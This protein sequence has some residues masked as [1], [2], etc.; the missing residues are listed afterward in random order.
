MRFVRKALKLLLV[1]VV[2]F[3][4]WSVFRADT[5]V[6]AFRRE[7]VVNVSREVAWEHFS[8]PKTWNSWM[9]GGAPSEVTPTDVIGPD[10]VAR[11]GDALTFRMTQFEP[12]DHWMWSSQMGWLT[13]DYD[14]R[15]ERLSDRQTRMVFHQTVTGFGN[16]LMALLIGAATRAMGHQD[17]LDR[18]AA[19]INQLPAAS[20]PG[21]D[22]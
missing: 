17:M 14:H 20:A 18:L 11:F 22:R 7:I 19:E 15:F 5:P 3:V 4:V 6:T 13:A 10:T 9:G 2:V 8:R 1:V 12:Y 16:D 21:P